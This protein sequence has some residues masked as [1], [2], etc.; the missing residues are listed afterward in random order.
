MDEFS[1]RQHSRAQH[2]QQQPVK[3]LNVYGYSEN[4]RTLPMG[5]DAYYLPQ[6]KRWF[7][8]H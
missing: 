3:R 4:D 2:L 6:T 8:D 5:R 7:R 1:T